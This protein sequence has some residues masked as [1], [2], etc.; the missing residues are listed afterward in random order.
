M[1][2][3]AQFWQA[4]IVDDKFSK[5]GSLVASPCTSP[6]HGPTTFGCAFFQQLIQQI[7]EAVLTS[8]P[9]VNE[10]DSAFISDVTAKVTKL[11]KG[12]HFTT[13]GGI[14]EWKLPD[15]Y[16]YDTKNTHRH[17]SHLVG[18]FPGYSISSFEGGYTNATIQKAVAATLTARGSGYADANAG[19]EKA[20][21]SACWARL[22]NT[23]Q[24]YYE[25]K[26][27]IDQNIANNGLSMYSGQSM[28][29]QID[30]NFGLAG[31][32]LSMLIVDLPVAHNHQSNIRTVVLGPAIPPIWGNGS[33]KGLRLRGGKSVSFSW[34]A[35][36]KVQ[37]ATL[38]G[39]GQNVKLVNVDGKA[40]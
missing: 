36:G 13:W 21:R 20:W 15:S 9:L 22:N 27:T 2:G 32:I 11:D 35:K 38:S 19:W 30:A 3:V 26:Y 6:E 29:F 24:A 40:L 34:D 18:W 39:S 28:P 14:K 25:L 7:F 12:V 17:L 4:E 23:A 5:D 8:A 1:K 37:S 16:G 31:A 33:V 10:T